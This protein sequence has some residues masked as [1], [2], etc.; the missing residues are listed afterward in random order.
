MT[1]P[2]TYEEGYARGF[3]DGFKASRETTVLPVSPVYPPYVTPY[4]SPTSV[5][6]YANS[7]WWCGYPTVSTASFEYK[8]Q[9]NELEWSSMKDTQK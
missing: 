3:M 6:S 5:P 4:V 7:V 9:L 1:K 8:T 2:L